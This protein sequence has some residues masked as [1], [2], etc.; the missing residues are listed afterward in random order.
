MNK[1]FTAREA[2]GFFKK[3]NSAGLFFG[4]SIIIG[5]PGETE[6]EFRQSMDFIIKN[7]PLIPKIEQINPFTYYDGTDAC[8]KADKNS[9]ERL[10]IF[11]KEIKS[12][13]FKYTNAFLG[14][15]IEKTTQVL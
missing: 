3:L 7:K 14:N 11:I 5:Y 9:A 12:H 13:G 4:V 10:D 8:K 15:L 6:A 2:V 1:G